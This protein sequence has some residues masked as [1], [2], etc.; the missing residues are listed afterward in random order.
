MVGGK[1][2]AFV[3][4]TGISDNEIEKKLNTKSRLGFI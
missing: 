3:V 1:V 4:K 2:S